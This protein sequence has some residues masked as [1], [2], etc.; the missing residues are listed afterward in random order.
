[1]LGAVKEVDVPAT[2]YAIAAFVTALGLFVTALATYRRSK[3][4]TE[5]IERAARE[6]KASSERIEEQVTPGNGAT[7]SQTTE[8]IET[9]AWA[10]SHTL[11][12]LVEHV[13]ELVGRVDAID[14]YHRSIEPLAEFVKNMMKKKEVK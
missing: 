1:M 7:L 2:L 9:R 12:E 14:D 11:R 13:R 10:N 8:N 5:L 4:N 3:R 6:A